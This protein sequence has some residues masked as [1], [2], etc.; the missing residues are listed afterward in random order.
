MK[1]VK[2]MPKFKCDFCDR[3]SVK[4]VMVRHESSCYKNPNRICFKCEN[5]KVYAEEQEVNQYGHT[6][7]VDVP[8]QY[9]E[10]YEDVKKADESFKKYLQEK[11]EEVWF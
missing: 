11:K 3:R 9:C 8:C 1:E 2:V 5:R 4:H 10:T 7:M 6:E